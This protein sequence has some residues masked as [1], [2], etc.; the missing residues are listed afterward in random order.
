MCGSISIST[1]KS[2]KR[3]YFCHTFDMIHF[4]FRQIC[5]KINHFYL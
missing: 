3:V 2:K 5:W 1:E 4:Q